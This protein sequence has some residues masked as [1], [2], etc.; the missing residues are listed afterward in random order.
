MPDLIHEPVL[1]KES[2][3]NLIRNYSGN[4]LDATAGFGG[5]SSGILDIINQEGTLVASDRDQD[6]INYVTKRFTENP[7]MK[8]L[9]SNFSQISQAMKKKNMKFKFDGIIA[10]LGISSYQLDNAERG[11]SFMRK[12][13]LDM[14]MDQKQ[15]I[16]AKDWINTASENDIANVIWR[17]GEESSSRKIASEIVKKRKIK[18]IRTT[19]N[20]CEIIMEVKKNIFY[21][22]KKH[23]A[24]KTFQGIRIF[25]NNELGEL[26]LFLEKSLELLKP[27]GRL[28][29]ISFHSLED[30]IVK[31]FF[32]NQSRIDPNLSR[33]PNVQDTS[34]LKV[35]TKKIKPMASEIRLNPRSRSAVLRVAER[36]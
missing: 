10:D 6:S 36:I 34:S 12:G 25:I 7:N 29:I 9:K 21:K 23:P 1:L 16:S 15:G 20:L 14:R 13:N 27:K 26:E 2:L 28:C 18:L 8:I 24:T 3:T 17:Y 30:R 31:R 33:L 19:E 35:I 5:H 11:F 22:N 32:R 4:Y